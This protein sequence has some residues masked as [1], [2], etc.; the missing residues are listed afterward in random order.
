LHIFCW[1]GRWRNLR[2]VNSFST[3]I[4]QVSSYRRYGRISPR[5]SESGLD[6]PPYAVTTLMFGWMVTPTVQ[7][8][9]VI[10]TTSVDLLPRHGQAHCRESGMLAQLDGTSHRRGSHTWLSTSTFERLYAAFVNFQASPLSRATS[11]NQTRSK[12][13]SAS[14]SLKC[15]PTGINGVISLRSA[16]RQPVGRHSPNGLISGAVEV[17]WQRQRNRSMPPVC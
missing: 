8:I 13:S 2:G 5:P 6:V 15:A 10:L 3:I 7:Q 14:S 17:D 1:R 4:N 11:Q 16:E 9:S 12:A